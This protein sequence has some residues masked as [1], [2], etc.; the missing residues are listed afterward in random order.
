MTV[1][2]DDAAYWQRLCD[3]RTCPVY[4]RGRPLDVVAELAGSFLTASRVACLQG[5]C[6][7]VHKRH[8]VELHDL[9]E[10]EAATFILELRRLSQAVQRATRAVKISLEMHGNTLPHL[11]AHVFPRHPGD[12]FAG[13]P[14]DP[15]ET[16]PPVYEAGEFEQFVSELLRELGRA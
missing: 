8:R 6:C 15:H 4:A 9:D 14:I 16:E 1:A 3:G 2:W 13:R 11:H 10:A 7:L 5:Q 12:R